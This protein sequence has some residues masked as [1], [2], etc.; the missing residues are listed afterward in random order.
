M[1]REFRRGENVMN[2]SQQYDRSTRTTTGVIAGGAVVALLSVVLIAQGAAPTTAPAQMPPA[3]GNRGAV[4][5][6]PNGGIEGVKALI[7]ATDEE[8]KVIGS[9]LQAVIAARQTVMTYASAGAARGGP[10]I[11]GFGDF[12]PDSL[13][14]PEAG[15][16]FPG[17]RGGRGGPPGMPPGFDPSNPAGAAAGA[18]GVGTA[19]GRGGFD[20]ASPIDAANRGGGPPAGSGGNTVSVALDELKT[21]LADS[22]SSP[23]QIKTKLAAVRSARAKAA[24][25][26]AAAQKSLLLLLTPAQEAVLVSLGYLD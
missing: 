11:G 3:Q 24:A 22:T 12:G 26:L 2:R 7:K 9:K 5:S 23:E 25:D 6:E 20:P 13:N 1:S 17:G 14:G 19:G 18:Q 8:W 21:T 4:A 15:P 16:G 10:G